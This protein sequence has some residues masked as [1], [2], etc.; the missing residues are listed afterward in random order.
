[1]R[2]EEKCLLGNLVFFHFI[3][4]FLL[5]IEKWFLFSKLVRSERAKIPHHKHDILKKW[6]K[7]TFLYPSRLPYVRFKC[8]TSFCCANKI[9]LSVVSWYFYTPPLSCSFSFSLIFHVT[10]TIP[11][12]AARQ[13]FVYAFYHLILSSL[14]RIIHTPQILLSTRLQ[15]MNR[16][17]LW[18]ITETR[19][20]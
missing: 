1:M 16:G 18:L 6:V 14:S 2:E 7:K 12:T 8:E 17:F 20:L 11:P 15:C 5:N 19:A 9:N 3:L 4:L 10:F 13:T